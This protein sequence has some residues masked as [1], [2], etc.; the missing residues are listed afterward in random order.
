MLDI[1][2]LEYLKKE[3][4]TNSFRLAHKLKTDR[5][6]LLNIIQKLETKGAL[7]IKGGVVQF[8]KFPREEKPK[9]VKI[10]EPSPKP[11]KKAEFKARRKP[12]KPKVLEFLQIENKQLRERLAGTEDI[13]KELEK[14]ASAHPKIVTRIITKTVIKKVPVIK[15]VVKR[16]P[17]PLKQEKKIQ[18]QTKKKWFKFP[19]FEFGGI[20]NLK[21]PKFATEGG[22]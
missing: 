11:K 19:K 6:K 22:R 18:E 5:Y 20:K 21:I 7:S 4:P 12:G 2:I 14:K 8:L 13:I 17:F 15:T 1:Q 16:I 10:K 9:P 3:G